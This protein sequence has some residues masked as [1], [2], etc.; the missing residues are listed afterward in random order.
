MS[1][2]HKPQ[3]QVFVFDKVDPGAKFSLFKISSTER[4]ETLLIRREIAMF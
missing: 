1:R 2:N 4:E 3:W